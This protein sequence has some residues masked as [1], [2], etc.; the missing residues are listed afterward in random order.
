MSQK[1]PTIAIRL[2]G[3]SP[4]EEGTFS[5]VLAVVREKGCRYLILKPGSLHDYEL[6]IVNAE[7]LKALAT[8][9]D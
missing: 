5:T 9:S 1:T 3:F 8:L 2:L 4:K 6:Y 7:D